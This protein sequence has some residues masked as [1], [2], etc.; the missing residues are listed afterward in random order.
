MTDQHTSQP[1]PHSCNY[2][3][4]V[5][6]AGVGRRFGGE[7]LG[8]TKPKQYQALLGKTV[9]QWTLERLLSVKGITGC[10][11][12]ISAEDEYWAEQKI[13]DPRLSLATGGTE[14]ADTMRLAL[15]ALAGRAQ[16]DDWVL[17]H[18]IARPCVRAAD[19]E[20]LIS[21]L[22]AHP[23]GGILAAPVADT[24]KRVNAA[25]QVVATEDRSQL[26]SAL[27]PQMFRYSVL[28]DALDNAQQNGFQP[29]DEAAAIETLGLQPA[30]VAGQRDNIK[31]TRRED[32]A[33]AEAI[34]RAQGS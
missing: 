1:T 27:T 8:S 32:L 23:V 31:I 22:A 24:I 3:A 10:L 26:W 29:T 7:Q 13:A 34:L 11:V 5:P 19:I 9:A 2:W 25:Q 30:V 15:Q 21:S 16:P 4:V 18:D 14:R 33:I 17:V 6:A 12:A 28:C 20:Q